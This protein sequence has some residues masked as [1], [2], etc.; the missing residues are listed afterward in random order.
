MKCWVV[1]L[2]CKNHNLYISSFFVKQT[3]GFQKSLN[4]IVVWICLP[5][6][7]IQTFLPKKSLCE[8]KTWIYN[9]VKKP[10]LWGVYLYSKKMLL[11]LSYL[12]SHQ[13]LKRTTFFCT[14]SLI[15]ILELCVFLF[16]FSE[17]TIH[18]SFK[19]TKTLHFCVYTHFCN[20]KNTK[21]KILIHF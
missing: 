8:N 5:T 14:N 15:G 17:N 19:K 1:I 20:N 2:C 18:T 3:T 7:K 12:S 16:S 21:T 4:K 11:C 6:W 10:F 9:W 13:F